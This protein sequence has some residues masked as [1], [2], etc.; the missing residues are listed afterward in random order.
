MWN[1]HIELWKKTLLIDVEAIISMDFI[2]G[3]EYLFLFTWTVPLKLS[4]SK[5]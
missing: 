3:I 4:G 2:K 1:A 5:R